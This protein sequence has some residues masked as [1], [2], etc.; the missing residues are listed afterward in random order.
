MFLLPDIPQVG[1]LSGCCCSLP[2]EAHK[3]FYIF[4]GFSQSPTHE[5]AH[6]RLQLIDLLR[7][8]LSAHCL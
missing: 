1:D 7:R 2:P 4:V 8:L 5:G 3:V 6:S